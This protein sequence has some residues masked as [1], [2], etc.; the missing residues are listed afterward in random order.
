MNDPKVIH[1]KETSAIN[2]FFFANLYMKVFFE[3]FLKL[4]RCVFRDSQT[5]KMKLF[6]KIVNDLKNLTIHKI[7]TIYNICAFVT[8]D[9]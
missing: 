6:V 9:C 4:P 7:V 3:G 5:C 1:N 8:L 2:T